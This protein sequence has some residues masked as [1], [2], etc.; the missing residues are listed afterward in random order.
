MQYIS[1]VPCTPELKYMTTVYYKSSGPVTKIFLST[2]SSNP[3]T[4]RPIRLEYLNEGNANIVYRIR[5][6]KDGGEV[7]APLHQKLLRLRKDK[8]FIRTCQEQHVAFKERFLPL[9]SAEHLVAHD[10]I[11]VQ[12]DLT[13]SLNTALH[14]QEAAGSRPRSRHG[15]LLATD[16]TYGILVTDMTPQPGEV[17]LELKPK[18]LV[19]SPDAPRISLRCRTCALRA[20]REY[21]KRQPHAERIPTSFCPLALVS[22]KFS[23]RKK[24]WDAVANASR[25]FPTNLSKSV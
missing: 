19:Q 24:A 16:D 21:L 7:P 3:D 11:V 6:H 23:D 14:Q 22:A 13:R 17:F 5:P 25:D 18:W 12:G 20:Q 1:C 4:G 15:D 10:L 9:F 2:S 8:P